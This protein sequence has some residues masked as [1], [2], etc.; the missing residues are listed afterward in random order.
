MVLQSVAAEPTQLGFRT[1]HWQRPVH[2]FVSLTWR[3]GASNPQWNWV[4]WLKGNSIGKHGFTWRYNIYIY[5]YIYIYMNYNYITIWR[6]PVTPHRILGE[7]RNILQRIINRI[8]YIVHNQQTWGHSLSKDK[9]AMEQK[10]NYEFF[11]CPVRL[12]EDCALWRYDSV[13]M[14]IRLY[15]WS[16]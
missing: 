3:S 12:L 16:P 2:S 9:L 14:L 4:G 13:S 10:F 5:I 6:L 15:H 11:H 8:V 7:C 1:G